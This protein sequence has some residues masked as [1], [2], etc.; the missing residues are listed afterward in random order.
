MVEDCS[1]LPCNLHGSSVRSKRFTR[2]N[3]WITKLTRWHV[4]QRRCGH[5]RVCGSKR[6]QETSPFVARSRTGK[7]RTFLP[8]VICARSSASPT[9]KL[10]GTAES[11]NSPQVLGLRLGNAKAAIQRP[12]APSNRAALS[13]KGSN[14]QETGFAKF[15]PVPDS[16]PSSRV[17]R[18]AGQS[19]LGPRLRG[20]LTTALR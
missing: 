3:L 10:G 5:A 17:R 13:T 7:T 9:Q 20:S 4:Q 16:G 18:A 2:T 11:V 8:L 1:P 14:A 15:G 19:P 6:F 12:K